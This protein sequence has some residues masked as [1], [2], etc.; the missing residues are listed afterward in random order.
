[1]K[2]IWSE[3]YNKDYEKNEMIK[4]DDIITENYHNLFIIYNFENYYHGVLLLNRKIAI[5]F[6]SNLAINS[7]SYK[8]K[9]YV[10]ENILTEKI[11]IKNIY[12]SVNVIRSKEKFLNLIILAGQMRNLVMNSPTI[13]EKYTIE[14]VSQEIAKKEFYKPL[15]KGTSKFSCKKIYVKK[16]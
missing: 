15:I 13:S 1:M 2:F 14:I 7:S 12:E 10:M 3:Q 9:S 6:V 11:N 5:I 16:K 8:F 4:Y